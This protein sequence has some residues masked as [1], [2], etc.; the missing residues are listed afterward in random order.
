MKKSDFAVVALIYLF[1]LFFAYQTLLLPKEAQSYPFFLLAS[2]FVLNSLYLAV[3][4]WKL[5]ARKEFKDDLAHLY[6]GF[7]PKQFFSIAIGAVIYVALIHWLGYYIA[8]VLYM[9]VALA[10]LRVKM[11]WIAVIIVALLVVIWLV[12]TLFLKVPLPTGILFD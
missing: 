1:V 10:L 11:K 3:A 2:V 12:F 4:I 7:I 6:D 5:K 8:S 9:C